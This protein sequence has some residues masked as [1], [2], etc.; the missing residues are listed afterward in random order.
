MD[1]FLEEYPDISITNWTNM[2]SDE[3]LEKSKYSEKH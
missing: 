1:S 3:V 2:S